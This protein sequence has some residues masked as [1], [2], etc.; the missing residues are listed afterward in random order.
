[1]W[2]GFICKFSNKIK[3]VIKFG[4]PIFV[5]LNSKSLLVFFSKLYPAYIYIYIYIYILIFGIM[6]SINS[7]ST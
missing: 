4:D 5:L 2:G 7:I 3:L 1:M 6:D